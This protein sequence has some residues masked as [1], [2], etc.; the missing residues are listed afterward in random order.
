MIRNR[1]DRTD[2]AV[3]IDRGDVPVYL[4]IAD[5]AKH[6][7]KV[8]ERPRDRPELAHRVDRVRNL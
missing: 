7:R 3:I 8:G 6:L 5:G 4:R 2:A 1:R